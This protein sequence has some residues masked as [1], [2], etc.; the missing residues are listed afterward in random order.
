MILIECEALILIGKC[1]I[2]I[3]TG[4]SRRLMQVYAVA[5]PIN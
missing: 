4:V 3:L 5:C 1:R 2:N